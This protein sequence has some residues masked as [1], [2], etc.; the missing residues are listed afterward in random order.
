MVKEEKYVEEQQ[1]LIIM[2]KF[3]EQDNDILKDLC[4]GRNCEV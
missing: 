4:S 3:K 1:L 2:H